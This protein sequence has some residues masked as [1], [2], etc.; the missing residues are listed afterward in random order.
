MQPFVTYFDQTAFTCHTEGRFP[1]PDDCGKFVDCLVGPDGKMISRE[2]DC[3]GYPFS[4]DKKRC[5]GHHEMPN[6]QP[7]A[8]DDTKSP[9]VPGLDFHCVDPE[10]KGACEHCYL[11]INCIGGNAHVNLCIDFDESCTDETFEGHCIPNTSQ[12]PAIVACIPSG[13]KNYIDYF[14]VTYYHYCDEHAKYRE[15]YTCTAGTYFNEDTKKCEE[16]TPPPECN[17]GSNGPVVNPDNC[18]HY[19]NCLPDGTLL[20]GNCGTGE[21]FNETTQTCVPSCEIK[22]E[23]EGTDTFVPC[24]GVEG[25]D[26]NPGDCTI[27]YL[28]IGDNSIERKCPEGTYFDN[29]PEENRCVSGPLPDECQPHFDY[30]QCPGYDSV[31]EV[32]CAVVSAGVSAFTCHTEGRFPLPDD[33]G[34]FVDCLVGP[35]GKMISRER[36]CVGYPFS[37]DKKRCV[38][39]QEMPNCQP[40]AFDDTKSPHVPGLDFHCV[41]PAV[42]GACEHCYIGINCIDGNAHV[43]LCTDFDDSCAD[44]VFEGH[45]IPNTVIPPAKEACI[46]IGIKKY[47]DYFNVTY[48]HACDENARFR[49][50]YTCTAGTYFNEDTKECEEETPP[51]ECNSGSNGPVVNPDNCQHYYN[52]LPDGT[53][54]IGNC[55]TEQ[56]FY[57]ATQECVASCQIKELEG[58]DTFVP[59]S[60]E[61]DYDRN[62]GDCTIYYL[63]IGNGIEQ[64]CP[65]GAYFDIDQERCVSGPLPDECQP[66]FDYTQCPGYDSVVACPT[67]TLTY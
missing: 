15:T 40:K 28:C 54:L 46:P 25:Y 61:G 43:N 26:R 27:Y 55:E 51:P 42:K 14:N 32:A 36:D 30:T 22:A 35:D 50:T 59:C 44:E 66:Q 6:C 64:K 52:C 58:N 34:K 29:T 4:P 33:C 49:Q 16:E 57:E 20:I 11:G 56:Y 12:P 9:H 3:V 13:I 39:H 17:S 23:L 5:V 48:Y 38:G 45:C 47:I 8:F 67:N 7:K 37:P 24:S 2:R 18:Q 62:P 60:G 10:V 41:D 31:P 63:C 19:Y 21:Y 53:L 1:L 65:E